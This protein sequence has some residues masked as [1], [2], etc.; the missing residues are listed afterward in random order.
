MPRKLAH[1]D[2]D[3]DRSHKRSRFRIN[4]GVKVRGQREVVFRG[5]REP[6]PVTPRWDSSKQARAKGGPLFA[7]NDIIAMVEEPGHFGIGKVGIARQLLAAVKAWTIN[8]EVL[9][10]VLHVSVARAATDAAGGWFG[11]WFGLDG[12]SV[13]GRQ[14]ADFT[15]GI[16]RSPDPSV[17]DG[18]GAGVGSS[19]TD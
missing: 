3:L 1:F 13:I 11:L 4:P 16:K 7:L 10:V 15:A 19:V 18:A 6:P 12:V 17:P 9:S 14:A 5:E 8:V 2:S